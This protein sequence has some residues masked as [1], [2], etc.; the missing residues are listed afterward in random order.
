MPKLKVQKT[1]NTDFEDAKVKTREMLDVYRE[2]NASLF[3][4][5]A[6]S[7]DGA[8]AKVVGPMFKGSFTVSEREVNVLI[9]LKLIATPF[10]GKVEAGLQKSLDKTFG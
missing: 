9:D 7:P 10:K 8:S 2:K 3:S 1:H 5:I 4:D 6:W